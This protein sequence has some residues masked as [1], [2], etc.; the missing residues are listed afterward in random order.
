M[1]GGSS[2][3]MAGG[4]GSRVGRSRIQRQLLL[5]VILV[6]ALGLRLRGFTNPLLD[7]QAWRQAD[8]GSMGL[9]M[10]G[11]L[12]QIPEVWIPHLFYD[13]AVPQKVELE[14]PF[15][16]YLMACIST[17]LGWSDQWGRLWAIAFSLAALLGVYDLGRLAFSERTGFIAAGLYAV[18]PLSVYYGRVVM[19][20]P[21]AQAFS[22]WA[23]CLALRWRRSGKQGIPWGAGLSLALA[24]LAKLPQLMLLPVAFLLAFLPWKKGNLRASGVYMVLSLSLPVLYYSWIHLQSAGPG[25]FVSGILTQQVVGSGTDWEALRK[26]LSQGL[27]PW[28]FAL[29]IA[30]GTFLIFK[31]RRQE[32][33]LRRAFT[34]WWVVSAGYIL[35]ICSRIALD[36]YLMPVVPLVALLAAYSLDR[37]EE[38]PGSV[39]ATVM[40]LLI[41][42]QSWAVL[43]PKYQWDSRSLEQALWLRRELRPGEALLL[44]GSPPMT[45]YYARAAGWRLRPG[46]SKA[47]M[48]AIVTSQADYLVLLPGGEVSPEV[49][50]KIRQAYP[51]KAPGIFRLTRFAVRA[52]SRTLTVTTDANIRTREGEIL[53]LRRGYVYKRYW[54]RPESLPGGGRRS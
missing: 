7:D 15:L 19:P 54:H 1:A 31:P 4:M 20:E 40:I 50:Q 23:L 29:A 24:V 6:G 8:T 18:A 43:T 3:N 13:G 5:S 21:I 10:L 38:V 33:S 48:T 47:V 25:Q 9:N 28:L 35:S 12:T 45:F 42:Y 16:P 34:V 26:N 41:A 53:W 27:N 52:R 37:L 32:K 44:S 2:G 39:L 14:F 46:N 49:E 51:E 22:V 30:G 11:K 36:Y 17:F